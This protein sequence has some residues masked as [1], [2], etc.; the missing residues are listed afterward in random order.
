MIEQL[1]GFT[2]H[3]VC[4]TRQESARKAAWQFNAPLWFTDHESLTRHPDIDNPIS[5]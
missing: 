3:G 1:P 4:A 2:L 5:I